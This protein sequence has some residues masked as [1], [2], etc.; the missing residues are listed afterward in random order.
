MKP[1]IKWQT[2]PG[3]PGATPEEVIQMCV[4]RLEKLNDSS[5]RCR[6]NSLAITDLQSAENWLNRRTAR[7]QAEGVE[8][9]L[10]P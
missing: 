5:L 8:G 6:E 4:E 9:T 7:R 1:V 3:G 2:E 10:L